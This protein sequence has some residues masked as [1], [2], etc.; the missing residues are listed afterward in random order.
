MSW[1]WYGYVIVYGGGLAMLATFCIIIRESINDNRERKARRK[2]LELKFNQR[3]R[4]E[5]AV[6]ALGGWRCDGR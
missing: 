4:E 1:P 5:R 3:L 2:Y 6:S